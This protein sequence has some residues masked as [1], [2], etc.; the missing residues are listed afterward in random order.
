[1]VLIMITLF[2]MLTLSGCDKKSEEDIITVTGDTIDELFPVQEDADEAEDTA[3]AYYE[4]GNL[5]IPID[6][7]KKYN[8]YAV[9]GD[10]YTWYV[11]YT[12]AFKPES[13]FGIIIFRCASLKYS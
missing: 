10:K 5:F 11:R 7:S 4:D 1:M 6:M 13:D 9:K 3:G 8:T 12:E 2:S